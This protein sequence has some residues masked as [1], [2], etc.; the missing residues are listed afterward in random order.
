MN[1]TIPGGKSAFFR[2]CLNVPADTRFRYNPRYYFAIETSYG[3][4]ADLKEMIDE[5]HKNGIRVILDGVRERER[6]IVWL[7]HSDPSSRCTIIVTVP[8]RW[9]RSTMII[10]II[11]NPR[12]SKVSEKR[13]P[14]LQSAVRRG[15]KYE[16]NDRLAV[17]TNMFRFQLENPSLLSI[18]LWFI[19]LVSWGPEWNYST[20]WTSWSMIVVFRMTSS[21][22]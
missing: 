18:D 14:G 10:G 1:L 3:T 11:T 5:L 20:W 12:I 21:I 17:L 8:L 13:S 15:L 22:C 2:R 9:L 7:K 19:S 16:T 6:I 4:T